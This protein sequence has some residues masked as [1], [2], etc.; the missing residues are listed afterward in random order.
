MLSIFAFK[1]MI[2]TISCAD[3]EG[4]AKLVGVVAIDLFEDGIVNWGRVAS[5]LAFGAVV[6]QHLKDRGVDNCVELVGEEIAVYLATN[7]ETWLLKN[8]TWVSCVTA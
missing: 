8:N 1:G 4:N 2:R 7:Q 3:V 6:C 5:L